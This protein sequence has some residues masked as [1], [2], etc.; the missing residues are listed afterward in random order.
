MAGHSKWANIKRQ[1]NTQDQQRGKIFSKLS[2]LIT[3]AVK[4]GG[5]DDPEKNVQLKQAIDRA[6]EENMPKENIK[7]AIENASKKAKNA[8]EEVLEGY[9][10]FGLAVLIKAETDNRQRTVQEIKNIFESFGGNLGEPGSVSYKFYRQGRVIIKKPKEEEILNLID[11]GA[12]DIE[13]KNNQMVIYF[14]P[15]DLSQFKKQAGRKYEIIKSEI[16]LIAK[17]K[18]QIS[19]QKKEK[20]INKFIN[21]L[22]DHPDVIKVFANV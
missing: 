16:D 3:T 22:E 4:E 13:E 15:Q 1:K 20:E 8:Q 10:P 12:K 21:V 7:R 9:G 14:S 5:S 17:E 2:K 6:K 11:Y 18:I 19:D